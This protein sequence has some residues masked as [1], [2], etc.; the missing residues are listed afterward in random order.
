MIPCSILFTAIGIY[1]LKSKKPMSFWAGVAVNE[2]D[3]SDIR[4]YNKS[5][6]IMWILFSVPLW[7]SAVI[8]F[9][10]LKIGAIILTIGC[11]IGIPALPICYGRIFKK[12]KR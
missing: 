5:N 12:H 7:A 9:F 1:A 11:V 6:G 8:G 10:N 3:I 2:K 4:S